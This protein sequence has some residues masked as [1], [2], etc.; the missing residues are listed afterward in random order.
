MPQ[1]TPPLDHVYRMNDKAYWDGSTAMAPSDKAKELM[2]LVNISLREGSSSIF[3]FDESDVGKEFNILQVSM[4]MDLFS[5]LSGCG[6]KREVQRN[7]A[8]VYSCRGVSVCRFKVMFQF[9]KG[10]DVEESRDSLHGKVVLRQVID[11]DDNC[12]HSTCGSAEGV[13]W[14]DLNKVMRNYV[15]IRVVIKYF[16]G[17][18]PGGIAE[19]VI[20]KVKGIFQGVLYL[21]SGRN[22]SRFIR[23]TLVDNYTYFQ[24][25]GFFDSNSFTELTPAIVL[26]SNLRKKM[27]PQT[28]T[29]LVGVDDSEYLHLFY[30]KFQPLSIQGMV[31]EDTI[32]VVCMNN[33]RSNVRYI[34]L[35]CDKCTS[36]L[37]Y[38]IEDFADMVD[39]AELTLF[40]KITQ[41]FENLRFT[42][43]ST[44]NAPAESVPGAEYAS[45]DVLTRCYFNAKWKC[46][47][48][49]DLVS[50]DVVTNYGMLVHRFRAPPRTCK[51]HNGLPISP[52][53]R[54]QNEFTMDY[55]VRSWNYVMNETKKRILLANTIITTAL[56]GAR[57]EALIDV[58]R[59]IPAATFPSKF[60]DIDNYL[61]DFRESFEYDDDISDVSVHS[62][63]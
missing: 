61:F 36:P 30:S 37:V 6:W 47:N 51:L 3:P 9:V 33:Y 43:W 62:D 5:L 15:L 13:C 26:Y 10:K 16:C 28:R 8:I 4:A 49:H 2:R 57:D 55:L 7:K 31:G 46:H 45:H 52:V 32:C 48:Q 63:D 11:H 54:R 14:S 21:P 1:K 53:G 17:Q 12:E 23:A 27:M 58:T 38:H 29:R 50:I 60:V 18:N 56:P 35:N 22:N 24:A 44:Y 59:E 41:I 42:G 19:Q 40:K 20:E 25:G 39:A 34:T